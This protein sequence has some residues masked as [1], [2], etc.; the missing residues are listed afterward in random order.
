MI[1]EVLNTV[2]GVANAVSA[3]SGNL[4]SDSQSQ[5]L[6]EVVE[7]EVVRNVPTPQQSP[8]NLT[9]NVNVYKDGK[10]LSGSLGTGSE[11]IEE[12]QSPLAISQSDDT[13][14]LDLR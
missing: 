10:V 13:I 7:R 12:R 1:L 5:P 4:G 8:I 3:I 11:M 2:L 14:D 6:V 9:I